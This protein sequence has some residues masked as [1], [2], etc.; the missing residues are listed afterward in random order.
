MIIPELAVLVKTRKKSRKSHGN[1]LLLST[2]CK[3]M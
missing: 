2:M 1:K 3:Y